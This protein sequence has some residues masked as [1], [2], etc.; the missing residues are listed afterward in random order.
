MC[1]H[2]DEI[3][4]AHIE[5][6]EGVLVYLLQV[7]V[8]CDGELLQPALWTRISSSI[9]FS[10]CLFSVILQQQQQP[11]EGTGLNGRERLHVAD[12]EVPQSWESCLAAEGDVM[13]R[14]S[15]QE[16]RLQAGEGGSS[17]GRGDRQEAVPGEVQ[18]LQGSELADLGQRR[19]VV[20]GDV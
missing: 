9:F 1:G 2:K 17:E 6:R 7:F 3:N 8:V 4:L 20:I 13:Q 16:Q 18:E 10:L 11:A 14:V 5:T 12:A 15:V 19:D